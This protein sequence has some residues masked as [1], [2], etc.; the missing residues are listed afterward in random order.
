MP[1]SV[2]VAGLRDPLPP[3]RLAAAPAPPP[4]PAGPAWG[5]ARLI[6]FR[7]VFSYL[8]L[9]QFPDVIGML[10]GLANLGESSP[11]IWQPIV[12]WTGKHVFHLAMALPLVTEE[13]SGDDTAQFLLLLCKVAL[14]AAAA[15]VWTLVDR[16]S[17]DHRRLHAGLRIYVRYLLGSVLLGYGMVKLIKVQFQ[18]PWRLEEPYGEMSPMGLLWMFMGYSKLYNLFAGAAEAGAALLLFFRRTTTLGA[19]LAA[20]VMTNV[21]M[22]NFSYDVPVKQWAVHL[23]LMAVFL[24]APDLRRLADLLVLHRPTAAPAAASL[25]I[26][27]RWRRIAPLVL[28][29]VVIGYFLVSTTKTSLDRWLQIDRRV[30]RADAAGATRYEVD[31]FVRNGRLVPPS[32]HEAGRWSWLRFLPQKVEVATMDGRSLVLGYDAAQQTLVVPGGDRRTRLG[33]LACSRPDADHL[34]LT[35]TLAN[36]SLI[37]TLH[38]A[39]PKRFF[40]VRRGFHWIDEAPEDR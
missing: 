6:A 36:D 2:A 10:P 35:G 24:L 12:S 7:F 21:V 30:A 37:V 25:P 9:Y 26:V 23:L 33:V 3:T 34:V 19:L 27:P 1:P 14:A 8:A 4:P 29:T 40:L 13:G 39:D 15:L 28:E 16:R 18:F 38:S 31:D 11:G 17:Q 20:A 32:P 22:I 5:R